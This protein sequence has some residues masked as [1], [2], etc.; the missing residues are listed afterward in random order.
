MQDLIFV[1]LTITCFGV[2]LLY[3]AACDRLKVKPLPGAKSTSSQ[4]ASHG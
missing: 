2:G 1:T 3:V 4:E